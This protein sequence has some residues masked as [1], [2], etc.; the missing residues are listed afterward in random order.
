MKHLLEYILIYISNCC[1]NTDD[2]CIISIIKIF[3]QQY[4]CHEAVDKTTI[5]TFVPYKL[6]LQH[7]RLVEDVTVSTQADFKWCPNANCGSVLM[8]KVKG[9]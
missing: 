5:L 4:K 6:Y 1:K 3:L 2:L 7:S 8:A 9:N